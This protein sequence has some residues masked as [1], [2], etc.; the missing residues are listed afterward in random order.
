LIWRR[1]ADGRGFLATN[2][3]E[4]E[5]EEKNSESGEHKCGKGL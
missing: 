4:P 1:V 3:P 5:N 2:Q